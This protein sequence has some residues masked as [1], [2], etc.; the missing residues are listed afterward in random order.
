[1]FHGMSLSV[2]CGP[3]GP[4]SWVAQLPKTNTAPSAT[5]EHTNFCMQEN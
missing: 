2:L 3:T 4:F 5:N 1:M